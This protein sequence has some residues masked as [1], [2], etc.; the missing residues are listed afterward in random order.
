MN[1]KSH[2]K[3]WMRFK[4]LII[5]LS[6]FFSSSC[7]SSDR[8]TKDIAMFIVLREQEEDLFNE[9][10]IEPTRYDSIDNENLDELDFE[11]GLEVSETDTLDFLP[12][13]PSEKEKEL[14]NFLKQ[15]TAFYTTS[16]IAIDSIMDLL[17]NESAEGELLCG[18]DM[19]LYITRKD[20]IIKHCR[21][22]TYCKFMYDDSLKGY[23]FDNIMF[24]EHL[25]TI[26]KTDVKQLTFGYDEKYNIPFGSIKTI[27]LK[28]D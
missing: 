4:Q 22:N 7:L 21:I 10:S 8:D 23:F 16:I 28:K 9:E 6:V 17:M 24:Y 11:K 26:H 2:Y 12:P 5:L 13:E 15:S 18:Y 19:D 20:T 3:Q 25:K 14:F 27:K 1:Q